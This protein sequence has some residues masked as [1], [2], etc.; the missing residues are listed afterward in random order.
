MKRQSRHR[1][2]KDTDTGVH[3]SHLHGGSFGHGFAG[4]C[5]AHEETVA[6]A[7]GT[8]LRLIT[9]TEQTCEYGHWGFSFKNG[10]KESTY[11]AIDA[12]QTKYFF[13]LCN[14]E[15]VEILYR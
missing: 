6:A 10:H 3:G 2:G 9:G 1:F 13:I 4:R 14:N 5:A 12:S 8:V 11:L 7:D 15:V